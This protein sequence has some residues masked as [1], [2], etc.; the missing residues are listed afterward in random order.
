MIGLDE[1]QLMTL[2]SIF[3]ALCPSGK[4]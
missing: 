3:R 2:H 1:C 4:S